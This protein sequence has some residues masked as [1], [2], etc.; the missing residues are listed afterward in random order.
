MDDGCMI[1]RIANDITSIGKLLDIVSAIDVEEDDEEEKAPPPCKEDTICLFLSLV[2]TL[3]P[4][5]L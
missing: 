1:P 4:L 3:E 5:S 2:R